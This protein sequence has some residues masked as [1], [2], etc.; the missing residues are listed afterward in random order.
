MKLFKLK[1]K[2]MK[3]KNILILCFYLLSTHLS[4]AQE[5]R[6]FYADNIFHELYKEKKVKECVETEERYKNGVLV[7]SFKV[8]VTSFDKRG[9]L[10]EEFEFYSADTADYEILSYKYDEEHRH[11]NFKWYVNETGEVDITSYE[12]NEDGKL[13]KYCDYTKERRGF[14]MKLEECVLIK[15]RE[16]V[17]SSETTSEGEIKVRFVQDNGVVK[18]F[19]KQGVLISM[20]KDGNHIQSSHSN[21]IHNRAYNEEHQI[22]NIITTDKKGTFVKMRKYDYE[23]G[24][25]IKSTTLNAKNEIIEVVH[26]KYTYYE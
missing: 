2:I 6:F 8:A 21:Q 7:E 1:I 3:L 13:V 12:Y 11:K 26:F 10:V 25:L 4:F 20:Y 18:V 22:L 16:G 9:D 24:L 5:D 17:L 14:P 23:D 19:S 15:Y